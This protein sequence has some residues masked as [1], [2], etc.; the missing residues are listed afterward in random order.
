GPD[1]STLETFRFDLEGIKLSLSLPKSN[2]AVSRDEMNINLPFRSSGWFDTHCEQMWNHF[3][4]ML[5]G[6]PWA[7]I[8]P[9]WKTAADR[10]FGV[11][12]V[13]A[14]IKRAPPDKVLDPNDLDTLADAIRWDYEW[15]FEVAEPGDYGQGKNRKARQKAEDE[16]NARHPAVPEATKLSQKAAYLKNA[17]REL[18][19]HFETRCYGDQNWLYYALEKEPA[20]PAHYY[21]QPLDERYYLYIRF[22][23]GIDLRPYFHLWQ[24]NAEAAEQRIIE[25]VRLD[26]PNRLPAPDNTTA[27]GHVGEFGAR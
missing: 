3:Y 15:Y 18:P 19:T 13:Q 14:A 2:F 7:Y 25:T 24:A 23:Y 21:C 1:F 11:L 27:S 10:T 6:R 22:G 17:L 8:G 9:F 16:Y 12:D 4:V 5:V 20:Y 26:F